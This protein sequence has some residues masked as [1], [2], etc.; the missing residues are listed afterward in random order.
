MVVV[1]HTGSGAAPDDT[2][3]F[4]GNLSASAVVPTP[5]DGCPNRHDGSLQDYPELYEFLLP[6]WTKDITHPGELMFDGS[7][8]DKQLLAMCPVT[9]VRVD[10]P[11][12]LLVA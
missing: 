2:R 4:I 12:V 9:C 6:A 5:E 3:V 1:V 10:D 8:S 11:R 7:V